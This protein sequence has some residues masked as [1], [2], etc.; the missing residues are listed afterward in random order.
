[1]AGG[2]ALVAV[3]GVA[4]FATCVTYGAS[5]FAQMLTV[6]LLIL[7]TTS[8]AAALAG[9]VIVRVIWAV[10]EKKQALIRDE[11]RVVGPQQASRV[12]NSKKEKEHTPVGSPIAAERPIL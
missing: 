10:G 11:Y 7:V 9:G 3:G 8:G 12:S 5:G 2:S 4:I 1:M 6:V